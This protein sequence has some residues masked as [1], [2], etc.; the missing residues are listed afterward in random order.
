VG[1][2]NVNEE[3][4]YELGNY[5]TVATVRDTPDLSFDIE[6][7]DVST[8]IEGLITNQLPATVNEE[9]DF[10]N[11]RPVDVLSP[12]KSNQGAFDIIKGVAVP[13][14]TLES[15]TY[16]FGV[17]QNATQQFT[18]K[19]DAVYYIPGTP[20]LQTFTKAGT[21]PY[22]FTNSAIAYSE[23]GDTLYAVSLCWV[24]SDNS[25]YGRL[26]IND[27]Y[28][29]TAGGFTLTAI[30]DGK[31]PAG[32]TIKAVYG[33]T[34]AATYPQTVHQNVS[35]KPAA[36]RGKDIDLMVYD[37][38]QATPALARWTGV[39]SFDVNWRANLDPDEEFGNSHF[40]SQDYDVAEVSG[41]ITLRPRDVVDLWAKIHQ[42]SGVPT[43]QIVGPLA[44]APLALELRIA[45]PET[46][47]IVKTL[48]IEDA[49]FTPPPLQGRVQQKLETTMNFDSDSG[50]LKVYNG[51]RP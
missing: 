1:N 17:R 37:T 39:Q 49:R 34:V 16:R 10:T 32:A 44:A 29:N 14:L 24:A 43:N 46:G 21:G 8:E 25:T 45:S 9:F 4:I 26:F 22:S 51:S 41:S 11:A 19:G 28:T 31:V 36:V 35:V 48:Y 2:I 33:S 30:G 15:A 3:K 7:L 42:I 47:G 13:Y 12:F 5:R 23:A 40:V 27:D 38:G 6:S 50:V 20:Y 18:F